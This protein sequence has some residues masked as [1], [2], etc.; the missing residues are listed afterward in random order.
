MNN[1]DFD[2][3]AARTRMRATARAMARRILVDGLSAAAAGREVG[4][5]RDLASKAAKR[6]RA[7]ELREQECA[8]LQ[9]LSMQEL[10]E[11]IKAAAEQVLAMTFA[12][13]ERP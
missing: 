6:I 4:R 1:A 12:D 7:E 8:E 13:K 3:L 5:S 10:V 9:Q 11:F 2:R